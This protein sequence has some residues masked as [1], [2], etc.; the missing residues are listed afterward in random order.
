MTTTLS[1]IQ[2]RS[3][4]SMNVQ[5]AD[6]LGDGK[7]PVSASQTTKYAYSASAGSLNASLAYAK[8]RTVTAAGTVTLDLN[9]LTDRYGTAVNFT[10]LKVL[11]FQNRGTVALTVKF[12]R[13]AGHTLCDALLTVDAVDAGN[14]FV[15]LN[16]PAGGS[17][18]FDAPTSAGFAVGASDTIVLGN[19]GGS[20]A[21]VDVS[22][23]GQ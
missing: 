1:T 21:D 4:V 16:L 9:A 12:G 8:R 18:Q 17:I 3:S 5:S 20:D 10:L 11:R 15:S 13:G 2:V 22:L 23:I 14:T 6:D 7:I 19:A